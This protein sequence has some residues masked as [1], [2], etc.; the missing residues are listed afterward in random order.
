MNKRQMAWYTAIFIAVSI[1][2]F[3]AVL[4]AY[5]DQTVGQLVWS[6]VRPVAKADIHSV[7][8]CTDQKHTPQL[9][10]STDPRL[11]KLAAYETLCDSRFTDQSMIFV[12]M[13]K[14][15][16]T[17]KAQAIQMTATLQE[18]SKYGIKPLVVIEPET[19]W[20]L[21][22]F[23]EFKSGFYDE[24][25][26][27]Y[28]QELKK[29]GV[30]DEQMGTWVPFPEA[31]LPY[32]NRHNATPE[33]F[34]MIVNRYLGSMKKQFPKAKGSVLLNSATYESDDFDW[35]RGDYTSLLPY[36]SKLDSK[37]VDSFGLQGFSWSPP[38]NRSGT[39]IYDARE[40]LNSDMA[41]EAAQK[42]GVKDIW[43]NTGTFVSKYTQDTERK[44]VLSPSKRKDIAQGITN[45]LKRA[46]GEGYTVRINIFAEDKSQVAEATDWSYLGSTDTQSSIREHQIVFTDWIEQINAAQIG[47][48]IYDKNK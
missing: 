25:I 12:N 8:K 44:V 17:A 22:D 47:I 29:N 7:G 26:N 16:K 48:S 33:D 35:Q 42:I 27:T 45:E 2:A 4:V 6:S 10:E 38:A 9:N 14:D 5:I 32:W 19:D 20:G 30:T 13:P 24:W 40:Y 41:I 11:Q 31:N 28:F 1:F 15:D 39:G 34:S 43:F 23:S 18:Y 37:L 21:I 46:Q 36:V 3:N